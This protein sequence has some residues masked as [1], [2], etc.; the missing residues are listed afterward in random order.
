MNLAAATNDESGSFP[1]H[2]L[3]TRIVEPKVEA[4]GIE[5]ARDF[6]RPRIQRDGPCPRT[7]HPL[8]L[9]RNEA[10]ST[11][12]ETPARSYTRIAR[13]LNSATSSTMR[14]RP[15]GLRELQTPVDEGTS[16]SSAGQIRSESEAVEDRVSTI[17]SRRS[18]L[19][20]RHRRKRCRSAPGS[21]VAHRRRCRS[22]T[23]ADIAM[24]LRGASAANAG[25]IGAAGCG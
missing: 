25:G 4:A 20:P 7:G 23:A 14:L 24:P 11:F 13:A 19:P 5:P 17:R 6:N 15:T 9:R 18:P 21:S 1:T 10:C 22:R 12:A 3:R 8:T 16:Q 2:A